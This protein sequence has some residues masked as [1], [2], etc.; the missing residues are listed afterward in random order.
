MPPS[1]LD[2]L[3]LRRLIDAGRGLI[4]ELDLDAVLAASARGRARA[5][6][7]PLRGAWACSTIAVEELERF[8]TAR[9]DAETHRAIGDLPRGRGI[10]GLLIE[11]P[12]PLRLD[13][14]GD[15]SRARTASRRASRRCRRFLG[16]P[17]LIRG[18][19]WGNLYLTEKQAASL[20]RR[21]RGGRRHP[22]RLGGDRDRERAALRARRQRGAT[23]SSAPCAAWRPRPRSPARSA[24]RRSSTAC[25]S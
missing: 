7:R 20:R 22:R 1:A 15:A 23:S 8:L 18:E 13:D 9:I 14:V 11:D 6:R 4:A 19:A 2:E 25:S 17:I 3:R 16:V 24:A 10:L 12:R 21:R 5:H